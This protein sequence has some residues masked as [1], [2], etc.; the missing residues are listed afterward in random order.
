MTQWDTSTGSLGAELRLIAN[1]EDTDPEGNRSQ[2]N[3]RLQLV[4]VPSATFINP[5][6][7]A[8]S[9][10]GTQVSVG[11]SFTWDQG[12]TSKTL[13]NTTQW[14]DHNPNGSMSGSYSGSIAG[15]NTSGIGGP[16]T[17]GPRSVSFPTLKVV[18]GTPTGVSASLS[19]VVTVSWSQSSPS[20][21][22]PTSNT[23]RRRINGG[24]WED[25]VTISPTTSATL[26]RVANQKLEFQVKGTNSAGDSAWSATSAPVY[27]T[28]AAPTF[29]TATKD[30]SQ[31]ITVAWSDNVAF[32]EHEHVVEHGTIT[33]G[34]T[35]WD[36]SPLAEVA[37]F[38]FTF[39]HENPDPSDVHVYR[40]SAKN[41]D[42]ESLQ[43]S[44]V[45]SNQVQLLVAPNAPTLPTLNPFW[46]KDE[47]FVLTWTHNP[48]DT[49]P[50]TAYEVNYSTNG[51]EDWTSSTKTTATD[52]E[53]TFAA[54]TY[55]AD[56]ELTVRVRTWGE[57]TSGGSDSTGASPWSDTETVT[58]KTR[59]VVTISAPVDEGT[60]TEA[61]LTVALG[62]SQAE[63]AEF[64][65]ATIVLNDGTTDV[66]TKLST[67]VSST[68]MD[69]QVEDGGSYTVTVTVLDSNGLVSDEVVSAFDVSYTLPVAA[70]VTCTYLENSGIAQLGLTIASPG[71]GEAAATAVTIYR[72]I[73]GVRETVISAYPTAASLA[74]LDL[75]PTIHG[76]NEYTVRTISADGAI[77]DVTVD[78]V[79][80][81]GVWA[82]LSTG[83]GFSSIV[84]FWGA[85]GFTATPGRSQALVPTSGRSRPI[86]LF[87]EI[88]SLVVEG[89][90][91]IV[92]EMG[93][94]PKE[95]LDFI[96]TAG[97]VC[98]R[99]PSGRRMFG[100]VT[101]SVG[102]PSS[103]S[104][105][106]RYKVTE[107]S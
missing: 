98:Y 107:A 25:A 27:T 16:T 91:V 43:S 69:T 62:F 51:G 41:T 61:D 1:L 13:I 77:V 66:E 93:S 23:V 48:V 81:E 22:Q 15:T 42:T 10:T 100:T 94:T 76:T 31:D 37:W 24:A 30:A 73:D 28:P 101:G 92:P 78:L 59:P 106:F 65:R 80:D 55:A 97:R 95:V 60:W 71:V 6:A 103:L 49:T 3:F 84:S 17:N 47:D 50:Q 63:G 67:T 46:A 21:G 74:I 54:D 87:G 8:C 40:V 11:S 20:N 75:I 102:S 19:A 72:T 105:D 33:G 104:S 68:L 88:G 39:K 14:I 52:S 56:D 57:A 38:L 4:S 82:F 34:V 64:V 99:D 26:A 96:Q 85:L 2:W 32:T 36:G 83:E 18:P 58:F 44:K 7:D 70:G 35:T 5:P 29:V 12:T 90:A 45:T 89:S 86:A 79:T 53:Y 9:I